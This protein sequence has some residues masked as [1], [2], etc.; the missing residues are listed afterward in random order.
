MWRCC[1]CLDNC[2]QFTSV[3]EYAMHVEAWHEEW[4]EGRRIPPPA[5]K[6]A[7]LVTLEEERH[8]W[9]LWA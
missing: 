6:P 1:I 9:G 7:W 5:M 3:Q 8:G 2:G 4:L